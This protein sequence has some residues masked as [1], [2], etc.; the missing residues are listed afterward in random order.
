MF[1]YFSESLK[2]IYNFCIYEVY[3]KR[4]YQSVICFVSK[5]VLDP[6]ISD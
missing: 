6:K 2:N 3:R 5:S 4:Y 1:L